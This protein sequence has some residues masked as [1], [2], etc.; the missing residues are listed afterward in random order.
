MIKRLILVSAILFV[1]LLVLSFPFRE[2]YA[3]INNIFVLTDNQIAEVIN[4]RLD[5]I[6][7]EINSTINLEE[8]VANNL[9]WPQVQNNPQRTGYSPE[10]MGMNFSVVWTRPF[11]PEKMHPQ[12]QAIVYDGKVF[13]GTEMGNMY[14]LNAQTGAQVWK[15]NVGAPILN[16]VATG[17]GRVYFGPMDGAVYALNANSGGLIWKSSLSWRHG[18]SSAPVLADGKIMLGGRDGIMYALNP[19]DGQ[20]I[21]QY[22]VGAPILQTAAWDNSRLIFGAMD[23]HVY[24]INSAD[25]TLAWKSE[26]VAG[27]AFKDYW[28]VIHQGIV[29]IRPMGMGGL[30][31]SDQSGVIDPVAQQAVLDDYAANPNNYTLSLFR[32]NAATGIQEPPIIHYDYQ[33]MNGTTS[34]PC[35]DRDGF[36]VIPAPFTSGFIT[37]WG[38]VDPATR[39]IVDILYDGTEAGYGNRDENMNL[40]CSGNLIFAIHTQEYNAHYN[41]VFDL[42]VR[43]WSPISAGHTNRQMSTNTQGGGGNPASISD[44]LVY[45]I[46]FHELIARSAEILDGSNSLQTEQ[47]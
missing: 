15:Y 7:R 18:I 6:E 43:Q 13:V 30:G 8:T 9:D 34:P 5:S 46:S 3:G 22:D 47:D 12:V 23:M 28:P 26:K 24:A 4:Y 17:D 16:S 20:V 27:M 25:G 45:H 21:W 44:G 11:Q 1:I 38:R 32:F 31:V 39:I 36:L 14:A 35:V 19:V 2:G 10:I 33:T 42:D 40:T 41:G 37:G 29:Y